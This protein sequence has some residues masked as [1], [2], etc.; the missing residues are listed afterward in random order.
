MKR[1]ISCLMCICMIMSLFGFVQPEQIITYAAEENENGDT[2]VEPIVIGASFESQAQSFCIN[3]GEKTI[4]AII[5]EGGQF[6]DI[7]FSTDTDGAVAQ[8]FSDEEC[9]QSV[10]SVSYDD[11]N[12]E[13]KKTYYLL[14]TGQ[15][16]ADVK[17]EVIIIS[18]T[19][20]LEFSEAF[21]D[22]EGIIKNTAGLLL[23][24]AS[25]S[26]GQKVTETFNGMTYVFTVGVNAFG[27]VAEARLAN[28]GQLILTAGNYAGLTID[29]SIELY[30]PG[31]A[32]NPNVIPEDRTQKWELNEKFADPSSVA[33]ISGQIVISEAATPVSEEG[34]NIVIKGVSFGSRI[35][36]T[37][38]TQSIY[39]TDILIE[40]CLLSFNST[41]FVYRFANGNTDSTDSTKPNI[42]SL[43]MKNCRY[44][45]VK[46]DNGQRIFTENSPAHVTLDG[47][48]FDGKYPTLGYPKWRECVM[49]GS[50]VVKNCYFGDYLRTSDD[51]GD[52]KS[53]II[54][55]T[56]HAQYCAI[57]N[58]ETHLLFE[59]NIVIDAVSNGYNSSS[60]VFAGIYPDAFT[61]ITFK[62]NTFIDKNN[63]LSAPFLAASQTYAPL[64]GDYSDRIIFEGNRL[65][66]YT[67]FIYINSST[68]TLSRGDGNYYAPYT[69]NYA[70][71]A[72]G[73]PLFGALEGCDYYIDYAKTTLASQMDMVIDRKLA[74]VN[75]QTR[76]ASIV[77]G[78]DEQLLIF[79]DITPKYLHLYVVSPV[80]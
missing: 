4:S 76:T 6:E 47:L 16:T 50:Y 56:G 38:R 70:Q 12:A 57:E 75:N 41:G 40:N 74:V 77:I 61:D 30:G 78:K 46:G 80:L 24:N 25:Y 68:Q 20:Q 23:H 34:T 60:F 64:N 36:D 8:L 48:Y 21:F 35:M 29:G 73:Q 44:N 55:T 33:L 65:I 11:V 17:Y 45:F 13:G 79:T 51:R 52:P 22:P 72:D 32:T 14:I 53:T 27:S 2:A 28:V 67:P 19:A 37:Y 5:R 15:E 49:D 59:N 63:Y 39:K 66:G 31:Y 18:N 26:S 1:F 10:Q 58:R 9:T 3:P 43:T 42:D 54:A 7:S 71:A 62:D 69:E